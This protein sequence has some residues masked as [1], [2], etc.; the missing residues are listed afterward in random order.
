MK[1]SRICIITTRNIFDSPCLEKYRSILSENFDII[2]WDRCDIEET[3]GAKNYYKYSGVLAPNANKF[4]NVIYVATS[5][6]D[7]GEKTFNK[8]SE[9]IGKEPLET[10]MVKESELNNLDSKI[11][12]I[13]DKI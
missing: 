13:I 12:P 5:K 9:I 2:Y 6:S 7:K 3:C 8:M 11:S 1:Q 4:K 10:L